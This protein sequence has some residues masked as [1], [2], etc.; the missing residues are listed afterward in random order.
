MLLKVWIITPRLSL[1]EVANN[2]PKN[3]DTLVA[4][5]PLLQLKAL[6]TFQL[7]ESVIISCTLLSIDICSHFAVKLLS[8]KVVISNYTSGGIVVS[9]SAVGQVVYIWKSCQKSPSDYLTIQTK[10]NWKDANLCWSKHIIVASGEP[11]VK[12][13]QE[14]ILTGL[15]ATTIS[16]CCLS[17]FL[18]TVLR[19]ILPEFLTEITVKVR[20]ISLAKWQ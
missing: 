13:G 9:F 17:Q 7:K 6:G 3:L 1:V 20:F 10:R 4:T 16:F 5:F 12:V 15:P 8:E 18:F 11:A 2:P 19:A 14:R